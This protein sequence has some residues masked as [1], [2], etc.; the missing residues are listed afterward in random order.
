MGLDGHMTGDQ[1]QPSEQWSLAFGHHGPLWAFDKRY[2]HS[3]QKNASAHTVLHTNSGVHEH[4]KIYPWT[5]KNSHPGS[6]RPCTSHR[7]AIG[8]LDSSTRQG[9][10]KEE[11][12]LASLELTLHVLPNLRLSATPQGSNYSHITDEKTETQRG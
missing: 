4:I 11:R 12:K 5:P 2:G 9:E 6:S 3:T 7:G 1:T 8:L 10:K